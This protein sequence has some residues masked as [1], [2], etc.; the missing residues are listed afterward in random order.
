MTSFSIL[1]YF[2]VIKYATSS[3]TTAMVPVVIDLFSF[4]G[5]KEAFSNCI[6]VTQSPLRL[7]LHAIP[8]AERILR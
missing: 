5:P 6:V 1:K 8:C 2:Y 7:K 3:F 4:K